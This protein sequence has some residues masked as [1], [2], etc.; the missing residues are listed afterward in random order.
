MHRL[1]FLS[2]ALLFPVAAWADVAP[3]GGGCRC[4]SVELG[5]AVLPVVVVAGLALARRF[6]QAC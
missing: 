6:R 1:L 2:P 5:V 3:G 4:S